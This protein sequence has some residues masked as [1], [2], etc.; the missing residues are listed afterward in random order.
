[1]TIYIFIDE[2]GDPGEVTAIGRNSM[3]YA[4]LAL[5]INGEEAYSSFQK[6]TVNWR[7]I[8]GLFKEF[9]NLPRGKD[10]ISFLTPIV[11]MSSSNLICSSCVFLD[12]IKYQGPYL[13]TTLQSKPDPIKFR[14]FIHRKL[15]EYH[16]EIYP[17]S[18]D[19]I[20]IIF[21]RFEMSKE[22]IK[23]LEY[24]LMNNWKLPTLKYLSH[25]DSVYCEALQVA[26]QLVN[27][28]GDLKFGT[29]GQ[30]LEQ[31]MKFIAIKDVTQ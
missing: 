12:K 20:E 5:Q 24:Y 9:K 22:A 8:R 23:N 29:P 18:S 25:I 21:D 4:E 11:Q 14:N 10:L 7:Y 2:S 13:K 6:H 31:M 28:V 16:F 1:M 26:S 17:A 3:Y 15:L 19:N 27:A 30:E